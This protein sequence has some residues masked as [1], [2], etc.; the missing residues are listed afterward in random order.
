MTVGVEV[1]GAPDGS[2]LLVALLQS[3]IVTEIPSGE[4]A[5]ETLAYDNVVRSTSRADL[6]AAEVTLS[7]PEDVPLDSMSVVVLVQDPETLEVFGAEMVEI[8]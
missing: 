1:S 5:G 8:P 2:E 3:G 7:I 4:N 6:G